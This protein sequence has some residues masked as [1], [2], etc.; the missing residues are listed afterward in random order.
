MNQENARQ[1]NNMVVVS[2]NDY[3]VLRV[4]GAMD[5]EMY[6]SRFEE[7]VEDL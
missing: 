1:R 6:G 4:I 2:W 3:E 5:Q 7:Y